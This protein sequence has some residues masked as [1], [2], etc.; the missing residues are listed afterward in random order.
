MDNKKNIE[1]E[2]GELALK[3]SHGDIVIIPKKDRLKVEKLIEDKC[4]TC[5][6]S[7]VSTLPVMADYAEDGSIVTEPVVEV[8]GTG[9]NSIEEIAIPEGIN[10]LPQDNTRIETDQLSGTNQ[11][12]KQENTS[13]IESLKKTKLN[14]KNWGVED[15]SAEKSKDVAFSKA[16]K[17][18][19]PQFIYDGNRYTTEVTGMTKKEEFNTYGIISENTLDNN[20][21]RDKLA[22][23]LPS[24]SQY[25]G[26]L[27]FEEIAGGAGVEAS[28]LPW[29]QLPKDKIKKEILREQTHRQKMND[30]VYRK[31]YMDWLKIN[32]SIPKDT[33]IE[34][35]TNSFD[36]ARMENLNFSMERQ[37]MVD[38][39]TGNPPEMGTLT[40][41]EHT[42]KDAKNP[43]AIYY[44][45][46]VDGQSNTLRG[47]TLIN[48]INKNWDIKSEKDKEYDYSG[49]YKSITKKGNRVIS[50]PGLGDATVGKGEDEKGKY[51]SIYDKWDLSVLGQNS[52]DASLGV[53]KPFEYYDR[54]YYTENKDGSLKMINT[55]DT[56]QTTEG[57]LVE[58]SKLADSNATTTK[59]N[60]TKEKKK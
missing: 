30:K 7:F 17:D 52:G 40:I 19:E 11:G 32:K 53:G 10:T 44:S 29:I 58:S 27:G 5:I 22:I 43:D 36:G 12:T 6:D 9:S 51:I 54:I 41:S 1:V 35:Y 38:I 24:M 28:S 46:R 33:S 4:W 37:D 26:T 3:N 45:S 20:I 2:G 50:I 34:E 21:L 16:K 18:G 23:A 42:P 25:Y 15:Y 56:E 8:D 48:N 47:D 57:S 49:K 31:E 39:Y 60:L 59:N 13:I 55:P 14:P